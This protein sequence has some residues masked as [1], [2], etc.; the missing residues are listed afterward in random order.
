MRLWVYGLHRFRNGRQRLA[1]ALSGSAFVSQ[2]AEAAV[3]EFLWHV[4]LLCRRKVFLVAADVEASI[5]VLLRRAAATDADFGKGNLQLVV[6]EGGGL[7]CL[8]KGHIAEDFDVAPAFSADSG[9]GRV[10]LQVSAFSVADFGIDANH[11]AQGR[12]AIGL[13]R[14]QTILLHAVSHDELLDVDGGHWFMY[15]LPGF[16]RQAF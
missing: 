12:K 7:A 16:E 2:P 11:R 1:N 10:D 13:N 15:F 9:N 6:S 5:V 4:H 14:P 3:A 8:I